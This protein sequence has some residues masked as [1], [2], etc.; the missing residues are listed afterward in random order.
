MATL[1]TFLK[2]ASPLTSLKSIFDQL[3]CYI[4]QFLHFSKKGPFQVHKCL[5]KTTD[6][7]IHSNCLHSTF[8]NIHQGKVFC[9]KIK[10]KKKKSINNQSKENCVHIVS[11]LS[12]YYLL[13][14]EIF[15]KSVIFPLQITNANSSECLTACE[16][17]GS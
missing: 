16:N 9:K 13:I 14:F 10:N 2:K 1:L 3:L 11:L 8:V 5:L 17:T 6:V 15:V 12:Y 4:L 7:L